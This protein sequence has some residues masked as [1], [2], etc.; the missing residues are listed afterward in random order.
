MAALQPIHRRHL[1]DRVS[2]FTISVLLR[3]PRIKTSL[4]TPPRASPSRPTSVS[5]LGVE[6]LADVVWWSWARICRG[7]RTRRR[8]RSAPC[9]GLW[10]CTP[11]RPGP[12]KRCRW[13]RRSHLAA[14]E[15]T[16]GLHTHGHT[17][18]FVTGLKHVFVTAAWHLAVD[19]HTQTQR[20]KYLSV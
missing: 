9:R 15:E 16:A 13:S 10:R 7:C 2:K 14:Q 19:W 1:G 17:Q 5:G 11:A 20:L 8:R 18:M 3:R 6:L 12:P 4:L